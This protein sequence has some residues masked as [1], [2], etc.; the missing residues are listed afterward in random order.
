MTP[1]D[2]ERRAIA[3]IRVE[4]RADGQEVIVGHAAVFNKLSLDLGGFREKIERGA[5]AK[6]LKDGDD[7][8]ALVNHDSSLIIGRRSIKTLELVEDKTGLAVEI[9]PPDTQTG[10]DTLELIRTGH[11]DGMSFG[12]RTRGDKWET[13]NS[14]EIRTLTDVELLDVGPVTFPAY[15]DTSVA[16]R[17]LE[18]RRSEADAADRAATDLRR[19]KLQLAEIKF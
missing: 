1:K 19:R 3:E 16:V 13:V 14:E 2:I 17:C 12:F 8:R 5:F 6:T 11:L 18:A 10:R 15:P 4:T 9:V 7:V